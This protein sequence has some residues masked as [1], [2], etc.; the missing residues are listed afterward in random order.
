MLGLLSDENRTRWSQLVQDHIAEQDGL[1]EDEKSNQIA[2]LSRR[3][4]AFHAVMMPI[5]KVNAGV[6]DADTSNL[7]AKVRFEQHRVLVMLHPRLN[8]VLPLRRPSA[9]RAVSR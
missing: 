2:S 5:A 7:T 3:D 6:E 9:D 8:V 1:E 4:T